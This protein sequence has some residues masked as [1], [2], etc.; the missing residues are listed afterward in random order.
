MWSE[1]L[2]LSLM[3]R[4]PGPLMITGA[5][6]HL[7]F[8]PICNRGSPGSHGARLYSHTGLVL[9]YLST[10]QGYFL[11]SSGGKPIPAR[12]ASYLEPTV[13]GGSLTFVREV[14]VSVFKNDRERVPVAVYVEAFS[15]QG[16]HAAEVVRI[17]NF[18]RNLPVILDPETPDTERKCMYA[19]FSSIYISYLAEQIRGGPNLA[20]RTTFWNSGAWS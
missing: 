1:I 12:C 3:E 2:P 14:Y 4:S 18:C 16:G 7:G 20:G 10:L 11:Q 8:K 19:D 6:N 5:W 9:L 13:W 17:A 15:W